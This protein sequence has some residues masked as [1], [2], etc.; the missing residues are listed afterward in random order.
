MDEGSSGLGNV[1]SLFRV[2]MTR[3]FT[4]PGTARAASSKARTT[5]H[6]S[7]AH[8]ERANAQNRLAAV[9]DGKYRT[10]N[11]PYLFSLVSGRMTDKEGVE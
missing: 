4:G 2:V 6:H 3:I 9:L 5:P 1:K 11:T 8:G 10:E 7:R